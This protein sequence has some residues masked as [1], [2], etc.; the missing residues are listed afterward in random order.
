MPRIIIVILV[1]IGIVC[2]PAC[3]FL[4][5]VASETD[6]VELGRQLFFDK[7]LSE[8]DGQACSV[9]HSPRTAFS[10]PFNAPISEGMMDGA[11]VNRNG[12]SL[13]YI[14]FIPPLHQLASGEYRGGLFW[15]GRSS[16][17][18]HQLSGPLFNPAEMNNADTSA[19]VAEIEF[20]PWRKLFQ[21]LYGRGLSEDA[22]YDGL[23]QALV[24][25]ES[26][27]TFR[28]FNSAFDAYLKGTYR[29]TPEEMKGFE[30]FKGKAACTSCHSIEPQAGSE[31]ILFTDYSYHNLG[32]PRFEKNPFYTTLPSINPNGYS[33]VDLGLGQ[34]VHD[35]K[36]DGKFR[37]PS[38]R[39]VAVTAP[40]FHHG[41]VVTLEE[42][43][44]FIVARDTMH[45]SPEVDRN[46]EYER[47]G[48]LPIDARE[49]RAIVAFL[50]LLTDG[51]SQEP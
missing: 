13:M 14:S 4:K 25:F 11:F 6:R 50:K 34:V 27:A 36:Q 8:P 33:A 21:R 3:W 31:A 19:V 37:T 16:D 44:H 29:M 1:F 23:A 30:L 20:A 41:G 45:F 22:M 7:M 26:S 39:N 24:A 10:D 15:D 48:H 42:A 9:C 46:M 28:P 43:V 38:L 51:Y 40:Y 12:N 32:L 5:P 18:Q 47:I 17:L 2:L 35:A 49:E